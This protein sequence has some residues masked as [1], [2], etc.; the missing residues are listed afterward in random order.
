MISHGLL[1]HLSV[2]DHIHTLGTA[3]VAAHTGIYRSD[4]RVP[5]FL[6]LT[7]SGLVTPHTNPYWG[8]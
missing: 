3:Y 1:R 4:D 7:S 8:G 6:I 2:P 5:H